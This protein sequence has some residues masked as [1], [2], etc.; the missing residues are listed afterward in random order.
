MLNHLRPGREPKP[1]QFRVGSIQK[2]VYSEIN[3][4]LLKHRLASFLSDKVVLLL[5][6]PPGSINETEFAEVFLC[7]RRLRMHEAMQ[8]FKTWVNSWATSSRYHEPVIYPC[9]LGCPD[10]V[11]S[12]SHYLLCPI[13]WQIAN[14]VACHEVPDDTLE[15][16]GVRSPT[17]NNLNLLA[18][19]FHS[20]HA[21]KHVRAPADTSLPTLNFPAIR[22]NFAGALVAAASSSGL[23]CRSA[24]STVDVDAGSC[25]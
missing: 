1:R 2:I 4:H 17:P 8:C 5:D 21:I 3:D 15:R 22:Q 23:R 7:L 11:D 18:C 20:Y 13:L 10:K 6:L 9:L 25:R 19:I 12:L 16:I 14:S 24:S